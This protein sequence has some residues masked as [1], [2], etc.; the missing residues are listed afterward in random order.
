MV[1]WLGTKEKDFG[2]LPSEFFYEPW[3]EFSYPAPYYRMH[4]PA[5]DIPITDDLEV[6][7]FASSGEELACLKGHL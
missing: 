7:I 5:D 2:E 4:V 3:R 6:V 1:R